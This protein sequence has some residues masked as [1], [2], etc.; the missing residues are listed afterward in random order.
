MLAGDRAKETAT[1]VPK[2]RRVVCSAINAQG[3][4]GSCCVSW[5]HSASNP[6]SSAALAIAGTSL[7]LVGGSAASNFMAF[8][9]VY[10]VRLVGKQIGHDPICG[11]SQTIYMGP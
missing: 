5:V 7:N 9:V 3:R 6:I 2:L 11:G 4:K 1:A 10:G 8:V